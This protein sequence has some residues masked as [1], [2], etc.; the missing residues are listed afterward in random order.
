[1]AVLNRYRTKNASMRLCGL[2]VLMLSLVAIALC[3]ESGAKGGGRGGRSAPNSGANAP[4][5][6]YKL[7]DWPAEATST[8]GFPAGPWNFIQ[9][10]SVAVNAEGNI[11]VLHR[12]AHPLMEFDPSGKLVRSWGD[13]LFSEGKVVFVP[14][15]NKTPAISGYSAVYGPPACTN[16]GAHAVR[17]DPQ[18]NI[19]VIDATGHIVYK[20]NRQRDVIMRLGTK[21]AAGGGP[22]N[23]NLPTD[24]AFA[25]NGDVYV[26]DG[27]GSARVVKFSKDGKYLLEFGKR[28]T[29]PGEFGLPHSVTVDAQ[30]KVYVSDRDNGRIE[31]FDAIGKFLDEWAG[32]GGY[33]AI[34]V[35]KDQQIWTGVVLRDLNGKPIGKL[36]GGGGHGGIAI[37]ASGDIYIGQLSG[38]VDKY[39]KQ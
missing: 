18:G 13:E 5:L 2:S 21:G 4:V 24:V 37:T 12:G 23:L 10:A 19:W 16:C 15:I 31:V 33:S 26:S 32:T 35:T 3:Q 14:A 1:M 17:V 36:P 34:D 28:G 29:G 27:Y 25:P 6:N 11:L 20:L 38:K 39:A 22:K 30:G 8:A 7:V 9:V